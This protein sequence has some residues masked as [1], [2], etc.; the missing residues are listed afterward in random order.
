M[1]E[2]WRLIVHPPS[3]GEW[4][5]A[6]DSSLLS[7]AEKDETGPV[8]RLYGWE[9]P[10]LS[11][12]FG[13]NTEKDI[14]MDYLSRRNIPLV[15]RPTGGRA[16]LH[17]D[18]LTYAVILPSSGGLYGSLKEVYGF[19]AS[20]LREALKSL[21]VDIDPESAGGGVAGAPCCFSSKTR[22][23]ITANGRKIAGS[24]QRRLKRSALQHGS[25]ILSRNAENCVSC[26]NWRSEDKRER[27]LR[28]M[29]EINSGRKQ[30]IRPDE[31]GQ[32]LVKAFERMYD[33]EFINDE[34]SEHEHRLAGLEC[35]NRRAKAMGVA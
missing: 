10:T 8:L 31:F 24:A 23:E 1:I 2:R 14:N 7:M 11:I 20:A 13:Q 5:M 22:F 33:I 16:I 27:A 4:N 28:A 18:E 21:E 17:D 25:V 32:A 15:R 3:P 35:E 19:I 34:L 9:R 6:V 12:G 29:G 26:F 30:A